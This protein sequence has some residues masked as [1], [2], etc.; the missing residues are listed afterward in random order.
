L[1]VVLIETGGHLSWPPPPSITSPGSSPGA[2]FWPAGPQDTVTA[3][4]TRP[5]MPTC[6]P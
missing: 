3:S 5:H 2:T 1:V 6:D 4:H